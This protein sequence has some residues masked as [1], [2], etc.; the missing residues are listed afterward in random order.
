MH[1]A[2]IQ[3]CAD[4]F[5]EH[6]AELFQE[7]ERLAKRE[8]ARGRTNVRAPVT[9][10]WYDSWSD[11]DTERAQRLACKAFGAQKWFAAH[12]SPWACPL[13]VHC[14]ELDYELEA[15]SARMLLRHKFARSLRHHEWDLRH[16]T[17]PDWACTVMAYEYAPDS[18]RRDADLK[19]EFRPQ[20]LVE[21]WGP[22][23]TDPLHWMS[24]EEIARDK[25]REAFYEKLG[26]GASIDEARREGRRVYAANLHSS[27]ISRPTDFS[28]T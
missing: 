20:K 27:G 17:L 28:G 16:P 23:K 25:A 18:I 10:L 5:A 11:E 22:G 2:P 8:L 4:R 15:P 13:P 3:F 21:L 26:S 6:V 1:D 14:D 19:K 24:P 12:A 7:A 9:G